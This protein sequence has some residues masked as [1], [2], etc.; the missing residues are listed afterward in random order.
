MD[1]GSIAANARVVAKAGN[2]LI[3]Q[4]FTNPGLKYVC[5][6]YELKLRIVRPAQTARDAYP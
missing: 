2:S 3:V 1:G 4:F 5:S 6:S